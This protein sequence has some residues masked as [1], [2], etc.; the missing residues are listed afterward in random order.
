MYSLSNFLYYNVSTQEDTKSIIVF[1]RRYRRMMPM[2]GDEEFLHILHT[3]RLVEED[4]QLPHNNGSII[5]RHVIHQD[6]E[7]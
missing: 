4:E 5:C 1:E 6:T 2:Y 7:D 3:T